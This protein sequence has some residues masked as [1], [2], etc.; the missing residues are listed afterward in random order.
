[1]MS[2]AVSRRVVLR[3]ARLLCA[4]ALLWMVRPT[5]AQARVPTAATQYAALLQTIAQGVGDDVYGQ[6]IVEVRFEG[7]RRVESEAMLLELD[8]NVGELVSQ[9]KL[10]TDLKRLWALGYFEDVRVEGELLPRGV[11]LT[12]VVVERPSVRKIIVEGNDEIKLDDINEELD[13]E[14]NE[15]LDLGKVAENIEKIKALYTASGFFLAEVSYELRPVPDEP[16]KVDLA[17]VITESTEVIV[18]QIDFVGNKAFSDAELRKNISTRVG[19]YIAVV[20]KRAGGFFNREQFQQDYAFL[21]SFY[22]DHGYLNP[23]IKDPELSLSADRRFVYLTIPVDEGPQFRIGQIRA[24]EALQAGEKE[25]YTEEMLQRQIDPQLSVG[26]VASTGKIQTIREAIERRYKDSGHAYVNV[27][28]NSRQDPEKLLLYMTYEVQK[29]PLVYIERIDITGNEKTAEKVIR[30]EMEFAEGD[31]YSESKKEGSEFRVLRLGYFSQ[32]NISTSRGSADNKIVVNVEVVEQLTGTF[33]VGAGFSTIENFVLQGQVAYDNFLGRGATVQ[34]VAQLSSLRRLFNLSYFTRYFLDSRW[35]FLF[36][37]FNSQNIFPSFQRRSTGFRVSWGYPILRDLTLFV[38]YNLEDVNVSF[39]SFGSVGG[40]FSPGSLVTVPR[41]FLI[42]NLFADG[43]TSALTARIQYDTRDNF[44]F[45][46]SGQ[47]H[48]LRGEFASQYT[49]SQNRF[50]RYTLDSRFYFPVIRSKQQFRAWL[51][52]KT[53]L[54][55]G[56]VHSYEAQGVPIFERYF[57]GGI[58]GAGEI[59]GFRLR[60]LGPKIKVASGPDPTAPLAPYEVGGNLLTALNTELEFMMI[61]PAN[62]KGVIFSDIGNAFNTESLFCEQL[63]PSDLPKA[64]PCQNWRLRDLRYSVGFGF[65]WRSPIGP[66]R[67]EWGFPLDRQRGTAFDPIA[68]DP[69]VFEFSIGNSF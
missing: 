56:Y 24:K 36:N 39:G 34:V 37:V 10:A 48:Q 14:K 17:I 61:P 53:R 62:I 49:G 22:G 51:V 42:S 12:Y 21:R 30:R 8:S 5:S 35:N 1:M 38:G 58:Y 23:A 68:D 16:G 28:P 50:N 65:R 27:I 20:A 41:Q 40:V 26:D 60:S 46:T 69:V 57:P 13:L 15:V 54:Q 47:F 32:V 55:V 43:I 9:R 52:F 4:V 7:N 64:D 25:L 33:Q 29:G 3:L 63:N 31:L 59:R 11:V 44:L 67:F 2:R 66:L 6:P 18:R 19:G 45:P